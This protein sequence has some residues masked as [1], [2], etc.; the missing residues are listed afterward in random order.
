MTVLVSQ[1]HR[2]DTFLGGRLGYFL[3]FSFPGRGRGGWCPRRWLERRYFFKREGG[4]GGSEEEAREGE[5][6]WGNVC[7]EGGGGAKYFFG[8]PK[9]PPSFIKQMLFNL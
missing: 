6:R 8:G 2:R 7:G 1:T 5:G 4:G 3:F 9:C